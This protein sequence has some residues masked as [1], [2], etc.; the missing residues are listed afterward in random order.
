MDSHG[1]KCYDCGHVCCMYFSDRSCFHDRKS[2]IESRG[3]RGCKKCEYWLRK[4]EH[5]KTLRSSD[6]K[7]TCTEESL[8]KT[9]SETQSKSSSKSRLPSQ[10]KSPSQSRSSSQSISSSQSKS[11]PRSISPSKLS[12][13]PDFGVSTSNR[14]NPILLARRRAL[15]RTLTSR[16]ILNTNNER[17]KGKI[18]DDPTIQTQS[19]PRD[20]G[21]FSGGFDVEGIDTEG[22]GTTRNRNI[23]LNYNKTIFQ[24]NE[25]IF[26]SNSLSKNSSTIPCDSTSDSHGRKIWSWS[27]EPSPSDNNMINYDG[28]NA[29][30]GID[31]EGT[32]VW[33]VN[34]YTL[35]PAPTLQDVFG[36]SKNESKDITGTI[37]LNLS[38]SLR[39]GDKVTD[40][41]ITKEHQIIH[42]GSEPNYHYVELGQAKITCGIALILLRRI[43]ESTLS[44]SYSGK[45]YIIG[46]TGTQLNSD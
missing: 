14:N 25:V 36:E 18:E 16:S 45:I 26:T 11:S 2:L 40:I 17:G 24:A 29:N 9:T 33:S 31:I 27:L 43:Q 6:R 30:A 15:K 44:N 46:L 20:A 35:P 1:S 28:I 10:S 19:Q 32:Y 5:N 13:K 21:G 23:N 37:S 34:F 41:E 12:S 22:I 8:P 38:L 42:R 39:K 3:V 4:Y 7:T